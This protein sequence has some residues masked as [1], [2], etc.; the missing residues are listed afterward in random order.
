MSFLQCQNKWIIDS[1][2]MQDANGN[3]LANQEEVTM[4]VESGSFKI[5][6]YNDSVDE[7]KQ[8]HT[9]LSMQP[10]EF[11][12][13]EITED[14]SITFCLK[15]F[16]SLLLF[17]EYLNLPITAH[18]SQGGLPLVLSIAQGD[19]L[20]SRYVLATLAEDGSSQPAAGTPGARRTAAA[21]SAPARTVAA[22]IPAP[23]RT[24][25]MLHSTQRDSSGLGTQ[26]C[27]PDLSTIPPPSSL[28]NNFEHSLN[29]NNLDNEDCFD[30]SPPAKK[31]NF[32]FR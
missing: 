28:Q 10:G 22:S 6:N 7:K 4:F 14:A 9:E 25:A 27:T 12:S 11:E 31:K 5:K 23:A 3:F 24:S 32:L 20:S 29:T 17:A 15:E 18:F 21:T 16:R 8:I 1:K 26:V 2:V 30:A 19:F 13:Y